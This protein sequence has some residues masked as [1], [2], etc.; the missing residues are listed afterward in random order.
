M[1]SITRRCRSVSPELSARIPGGRPGRDRLCPSGFVASFIAC[2]GSSRP[3]ERSWA[4]MVALSAVVVTSA[5]LDGLPCSATV[6][7]FERLR[8]THVRVKNCGWPAVIRFLGVWLMPYR[9]GAGVEGGRFSY[10]SPP[11][12]RPRGPVLK[13]AIRNPVSRDS[14]PVARGSHRI[15]ACSRRYGRA[16]H[17][18]TGATRVCVRMCGPIPTSSGWIT[19]VAQKLWSPGSSTPRASP[20]LGA[21]SRGSRALTR[22]LSLL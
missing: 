6:V 4:V 9:P 5:P 15:S 10:P 3:W 1:T 8:Q 18:D 20:M 12:W 17:A 14:T 7:A 13:S 21:A 11:E 16:A 22:L 19:A 2:T